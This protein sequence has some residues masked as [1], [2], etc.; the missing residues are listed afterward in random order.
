MK[1]P[2]ANAM[3]ESESWIRH[4]LCNGFFAYCA[5]DCC[6]GLLEKSKKKHGSFCMIWHYHRRTRI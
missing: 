4:Q 2:Y 3:S 1:T 5:M 6:V